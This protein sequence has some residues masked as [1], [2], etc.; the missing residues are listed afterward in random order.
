MLRFFLRVDQSI[1]HDILDVG[2]IRRGIFYSSSNGCKQLGTDRVWSQNLVFQLN[3]AKIRLPCGTNM[4]NTHCNNN[5][6]SNSEIED[7]CT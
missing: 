1:S 4:M 3:I 5:M 7:T 2:A 6:S